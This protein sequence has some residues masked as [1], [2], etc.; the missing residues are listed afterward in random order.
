MF[1]I[2]LND[3][4]HIKIELQPLNQLQLHSEIIFLNCRN[5]QK[6][7]RP[8]SGA[9]LKKTRL[10]QVN[11]KNIQIYENICLNHVFL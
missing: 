5:L 9:P 10:M 1:G 8:R 6:S 11:T 3:L 2:S 4:L 7:S